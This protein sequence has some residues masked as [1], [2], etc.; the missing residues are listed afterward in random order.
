[1]GQS[2]NLM[3]Y[4]K[5]IPKIN[6]GR[7]SGTPIDQL[8]N[9][10]LRWMLTQDF[11]K[12]WLDVAKRKLDASVYSDEFISVTRHAYD[13]FSLRFME[14]YENREDKGV[15]LGT[16]LSQLAVRAFK[17]GTDTS[18]HRHS[19]DGVVREYEGIQWVY[20]VSNRFP[21]YKDVITVMPV[22]K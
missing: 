20:G 18:K 11:P 22:N 1:M 14:L 17:D 16:F 7:Y 9:S 19:G 5:K 10:Y 12:E 15:G 2:K 4:R 6:V 8:P 21:D 13:Q 3:A